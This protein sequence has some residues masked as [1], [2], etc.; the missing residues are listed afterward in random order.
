MDGTR[1]RYA[2]KSGDWVELSGC[3]ELP[4]RKLDALYTSTT[5]AAFE[6]AKGVVTAWQM[7]A[8]GEAVERG[9]MMGLT[10]QQWDWLREQIVTAARDEAL[11][12]E[13]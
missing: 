3:A 1:M 10:L 12:P 13:A 2:R 8:G 6:I 9:D 11:D 4:M 5:A 7:T